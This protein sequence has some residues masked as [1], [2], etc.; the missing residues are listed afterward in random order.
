MS[1][2]SRQLIALDMLSEEMTEALALPEVSQTA[3]VS[4]EYLSLLSQYRRV[5]ESLGQLAAEL[6]EI[7][8]SETVSKHNVCIHLVN[9]KVLMVQNKLLEY[10]VDFYDASRR[11]ERIRHDEF[12]Q[13]ADIRFDLLS[14]RAIKLRSQFKTIAKAMKQSDYESLM[15]GIGL[16]DFDWGWDVLMAI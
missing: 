16:A 7:G 3:Q 4:S 10:A 15:R 9:K 1:T 5:S 2:F 13:Q 14:T 8:F 11:A 12:N 6:T